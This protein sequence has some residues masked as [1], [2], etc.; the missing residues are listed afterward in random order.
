MGDRE[1]RKDRLEGNGGRIVV[2]GV[3]DDITLISISTNCH[4]HSRDHSAS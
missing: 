4:A 2:F 3:Y 1:L